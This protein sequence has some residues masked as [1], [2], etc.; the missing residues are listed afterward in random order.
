MLA[1]VA[2]GGQMQD[3]SGRRAVPAQRWVTYSGS[4][5]IVTLFSPVAK[6]RLG[7]PKTTECGFCPVDVD[8]TRYLLLET[9]GAADREIPGKVSQSLHLDRDRAAELKQLLERHFPGI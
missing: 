9:Y 7:R 5:A 3:V 2:F 8:G 4:M 1:V 6:D